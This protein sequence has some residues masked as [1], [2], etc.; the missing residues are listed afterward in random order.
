MGTASARDA[1]ELGEDQLVLVRG[2]LV[3][4]A[5]EGARGK[6]GAALRLRVSDARGALA[7]LVKEPAV[8][9][10]RLEGSALVIEGEDA[11]QLASATGR[12]L[13]RSGVRV[14]AVIAEELEARDSRPR[15]A[16]GRAAAPVPGAP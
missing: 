12:A 7:E 9:S 8:A 4:A 5:S 1:A 3:P 16:L 6:K 13:H 11:I 15:P 14:D 10:F 2:A